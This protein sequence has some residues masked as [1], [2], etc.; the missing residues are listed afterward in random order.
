MFVVEHKDMGYTTS[1]HNTPFFK[2]DTYMWVVVPLNN[3]E[4]LLATLTK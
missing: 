4:L 1:Q 2:T 3:L